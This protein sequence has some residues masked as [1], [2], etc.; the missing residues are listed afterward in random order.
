MCAEGLRG[1][2]VKFDTTAGLAVGSHTIT[3]TYS[4][5]GLFAGSS[6]PLAGGQSVNMA[7]TS[8]KVLTITPQRF[9]EAE[10]S[11]PK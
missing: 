7:A 1:G 2:K 5:E 10:V 8:T 11:E 3:A 9:D 4:A 6:A